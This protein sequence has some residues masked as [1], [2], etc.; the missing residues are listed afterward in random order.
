MK[1]EDCFYR[2]VDTKYPLV[3]YYVPNEKEAHEIL[4][5]LYKKGKRNIALIDIFGTVIKEY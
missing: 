4:E 5:C 1:K 3:L 2:I